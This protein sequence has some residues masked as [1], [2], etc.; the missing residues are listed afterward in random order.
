MEERA[1]E[2]M[3]RVRARIWITFNVMD[4]ASGDM[5]YEIVEI[6]QERPWRTRIGANLTI[7]TV[8][9]SWSQILVSM[10]MGRQIG[11]VRAMSMCVKLNHSILPKYRNQ[12]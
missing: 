9:N 6:G 8:S 1:K 2:R 12:R 3:A 4:V 5:L 10:L 7:L 11:L